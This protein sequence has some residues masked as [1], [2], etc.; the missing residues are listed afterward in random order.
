[1]MLRNDKIVRCDRIDR[2]WGHRNHRWRDL[3]MGTVLLTTPYMQL[4]LT[5]TEMHVPS[6]YNHRTA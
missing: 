1:M 2:A 4:G 5:S 6:C 3:C